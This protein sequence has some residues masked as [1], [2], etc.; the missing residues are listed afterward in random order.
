MNRPLLVVLLLLALVGGAV[1]FV[2]GAFVLTDRG[3]P[4]PADRPVAAGGVAETGAEAADEPSVR[5]AKTAD[6]TVARN[7]A[8]AVAGEV[9][10]STGAPVEGAVV[11]CYGVPPGEPDDEVRIARALLGSLVPDQEIE[12]LVKDLGGIEGLTNSGMGGMRAG[13]RARTRARRTTDAAAGGAAGPTVTRESVAE[14]EQSVRAMRAG[15]RLGAKVMSDPSIVPRLQRVA[16]LAGAGV[17][18]DASLELLAKATSDASG[19]FRID[20]L[21]AGRVE[22]RVGAPRFQRAKERVDVGATSVAIELDVAGVVTGQVVCEGEPV[23]GASV[24]TRTRTL[25][26]GGDGRFSHDGAQPPREPL[27]VSADGCVPA[28][29]WAPV[30]TDGAPE[31]VTIALDPAGSV[32]GRVVTHDGKPVEG[33]VI[34]VASDPTSVFAMM[35]PGGAGDRLPAADVSAWT[36][37]DGAYHLKSVRPG[38]LRLRAEAPGFLPATA[39]AVTV[40]RRETTDGVDFVLLRESALE[41]R[42]TDAAGAPLAGATVKV[43]IPGEGMMRMAAQ[44]MGGIWATATSDADGRYRVGGV[45][46][47]EHDVVCEAE[48]HLAATTKETLVAEQTTQR[49]FTLAPGHRLDGVVLDPA[50]A[51]VPGSTVRVQSA[52]GSDAN[53]FAAMMGGGEAKTA[54][55]DVEGKWAASGL[56][57]GPYTVT[58]AAPRYLEASAADVAPGTS[59]L[60][61]QLGAAATLR[62]RVVASEGGA[63]V[64]GAT[65]FRRGKAARGPGGPFG[66]MFARDPEV[67]TAPDGTFEIPGLA[68]GPWDLWAR[69]PGYAESARLKVTAAGG[70]TVGDLTLTLPPGASLAGRV[71]RKGAG[72]P[73]EGAVVYVSFERGML[74][75]VNPSDFVDGPPSAP[76]NSASAKSDA[77]GQFVVEGLTPGKVQL[78]VRAQGLAPLT[79]AATDV[80]GSGVVAELSE[81][82]AVE[83]Q[84]YAKDGSP[85]DGATVMVQRGMMGQGGRM[86]TTEDGGRFRIA[87]LPPGSYQIMLMDPESPMGVG[88]MMSVSVRDG[89]TTRHDFGKPGVGRT[90]AGVVVRDAKPMS[91][92]TVML[93]GG[94]AGMRLAETGADGRFSIP[95]LPPGE[96]QVSVQ[97]NMMGGGNTSQKVT[98][99]E[100]GDPAELRLEVSSLAVTG[101]V[102]DAETGKPVPLAQVLL[103]APSSGRGGSLQDMV[104]RQRGQSFTG[105]DGT[106]SIENVPAGAFTVRVSASG[107]T[108]AVIDGVAAGGAAVRVQ[109]SRGAEL[110]VTVLGPDRK[111]LQNAAVVPEDPNGSEANPFDLTMS[112]ITGADGVARLRLAPGRTVVHIRAQGFPETTIEADASAGAVTVKLDAGAGIDLTVKTAAGAPVAGATIR[113]LD[114]SGAEITSS[115]TMGDLFGASSVTDATGRATRDGLRG[116]KVTVIAKAP[117]GAEARAAATLAAGETTK[118]ELTIE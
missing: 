90:V 69:G 39:D 2:V 55:T 107:Y 98:V 106:F 54:V 36:G 22:L 20:G 23:P 75:G 82:G 78:E 64:G 30:A 101:S 113:L 110:A 37:A 49:D 24:R 52:G 31:P 72:T 79:L 45:G 114:A 7:D 47:G 92:A 1:A 77:D 85:K 8:A 42:V 44:F 43:S 29:R 58:A 71:V 50:G 80:P 91:G 93:F 61:L 27:F 16:A 26:T 96:Y 38:S 66:G 51:P 11:E 60:V 34:G 84:V 32:R 83:G 105:N 4:A 94:Q 103:L 86:A 111:P 13:P 118:L 41:G 81:G 68:P 67:R 59:G 48:G 70:E 99:T 9:R 5:R 40:V 21:A 46:E 19:R 97:S 76:A 109:M 56:P 17:E 104:A 12:G 14:L 100:T 63:G 18:D 28:S 25:R 102:V 74:A 87:R 117:S 73:V 6:R 62:G 57:E 89:E 88:G 33:A 3:D 116:G 112:K 108:E 10:S 15:M 53:P 95:G 35:M 65:V 115:M